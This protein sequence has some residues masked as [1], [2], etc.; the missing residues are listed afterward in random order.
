MDIIE[1]G[2]QASNS[3]SQEM[4]QSCANKVIIES[5]SEGIVNK[6]LAENWDIRKDKQIVGDDD[7][8]S[9]QVTAGTCAGKLNKAAG[10]LTDV[11]Q[12]GEFVVGGK[13]RAED[14]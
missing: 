14:T 4:I 1:K 13:G 2:N 7:M 6:S 11:A 12:A 5:Y 3:I 10:I 8:E 9:S